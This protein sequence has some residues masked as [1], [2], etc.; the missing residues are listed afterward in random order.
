[1]KISIHHYTH[2]FNIKF[3]TMRQYIKKVHTVTNDGYTASYYL[4]GI[5]INNFQSIND[6]NENLK[7]DRRSSKYSSG[8]KIKEIF[9]T[10][11]NDNNISI[12]KET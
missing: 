1:M 12:Y 11:I 2:E 9:I 4:S 8:T 5:N 6:I 3:G 7:W 10:D